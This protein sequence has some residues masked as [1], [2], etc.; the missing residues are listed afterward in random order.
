MPSVFYYTDVGDDSENFTSATFDGEEIT[1]MWRLHVSDDTAN[2][3]TGTLL[4]WSFDIE[5]GPNS[6]G[7]LNHDG[8]VDA[9]GLACR[10]MRRYSRYNE[11]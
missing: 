8:V 5:L 7:N 10:S 3:E 11:R 4:N 9:D 2:G 1:G 6:N